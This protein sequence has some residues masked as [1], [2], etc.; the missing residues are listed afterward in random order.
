MSRN[1]SLSNCRRRG[2]SV[3]VAVMG[4][5]MIVSMVALT[6]SLTGRLQL[7]SNQRVESQLRASLAARSGVEYALNW[8]NRNSDWRSVLAS[9]VDQPS[10]RTSS[11]QFEWRVTDVDGDLADDAR[12]HAVLRVAGFDSGA[13]VCTYVLEVGIEPA[14]RPL[15]CLESAVH[16]GTEVV[17]R[18]GA[19]LNG[20]GIVSA[21]DCIQVTGGVATIDLDAEA[22]NLAKGAQYNGEKTNGVASREMPG[23][24][25]FD[26]YIER[27]TEIKIADLETV[28][29]SGD[30]RI[31]TKTFSRVV[32]PYGDPNP[33]GIYWIDCG[34]QNV[35][36]QYVRSLGTLVLL[37]PGASTEVEDVLL[38]Q[39]E[40]Q[41]YPVLMVDGDLSIDLNLWFTGQKLPE[42]FG[43][44]YN[45]VGVPYLGVEDT[46]DD[47]EYPARLD[48]IVYV[49]GTITITDDADFQGNLIAENIVVNDNKTLKVDYRDYA[50]NY[51]PPGFSAGQG[52]RIL[53]GT[54]RRVGL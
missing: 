19:T 30:K 32:S 41:N 25:V 18:G 4:V 13:K 35:R 12:D 34:G 36:V 5:G 40:A 43:V 23:E 16:A 46:D 14:G 11:G 3:Y 1:L 28:P 7:R 26:W 39:A 22:V 52:V 38:L 29:F 27:G 42:G 37:N 17:I 9:G 15:S 54:Y 53:P 50:H 8:M 45:P 44:N 6:T 47:D 10:V 21:N 51:P 33:L 24:H 31:S 48:G 2:A 20:S 49:T